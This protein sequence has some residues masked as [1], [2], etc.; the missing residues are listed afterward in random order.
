MVSASE[1]ADRLDQHRTFVDAAAAAGVGHIVY[2]SFVGAAPDATFT[3]VRDHYATEEYIKRR[4]L[5]TT[6][7]CG[8][9]S[10]ST[11]WRRWSASDGNISGPA[12]E[13]RA[14]MV[15]RTD[16]ARVA[17]TILTDP[18]AHAGKQ[19]DLTG[20]EALTLAEAAQTISAAR[21]RPIG[22]RNETIEEAYA[23]RASYGAPDWQVEAWVSTYTAIAAGEMD[24]VTDHVERITGRPP[25]S[26][27]EHLASTPASRRRYGQSM[28]QVADKLERSSERIDD[29]CRRA[30]RDPGEVRLLPVS[31]THGPEV[32]ARGVRRG[33]P[34]VRGEPGAGGGGEGRALR[35]PA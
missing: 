11:S 14:G 22:F 9:T 5:S 26:L 21:D 19:Y 20:P 32:I 34:A 29:A 31:K 6:P 2:T 27:A 12:D 30:G 7:S 18:E 13:G 1:S 3:L 16:V 25:I 8:T 28:G 15:A 33:R 23:S 17:A 24:V 35:R 10:I 4:G